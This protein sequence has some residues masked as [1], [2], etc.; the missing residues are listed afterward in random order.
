MDNAQIEER[1]ARAHE[2]HRKGFNCAQAVACTCADLIG[3]DEATAFR[4]TEGLGRGMGCFSETC[5]AVSG[6]VAVIGYA[7]S[8]GPHDPRTKGAT[9]QQVRRLVEGFRKQNGSTLCR[10]LKGLDGGPVLRACPDC[11]EDVI[12]MTLEILQDN[13]AVG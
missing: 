13:G 6:G 11:V 8:E 5:G 3:L 10:E 4:M 12:R 1:V 7:Q 9:Y 2:L